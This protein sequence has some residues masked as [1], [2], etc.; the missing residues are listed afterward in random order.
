MPSPAAV[1]RPMTRRPRSKQSTTPWPRTKADMARRL[2]SA[3]R[4]AEIIRWVKCARKLRAGRRRFGKKKVVRKAGPK[5]IGC[6][7]KRSSGSAGVEAEREAKP[8]ETKTNP[9][10]RRRFGATIRRS[11]DRAQ[12]PGAT[13]RERQ[14]PARPSGERERSQ[15][16]HREQKAERS[17]QPDSLGW[18]KPEPKQRRAPLHRCRS[19][20]P[21]CSMEKP[22][23]RRSRAA[24]R[25][26]VQM[27]RPPVIFPD[28][29]H[30]AADHPITKHA[31]ATIIERVPFAESVAFL[32]DSQLFVKPDVPVPHSFTR[33]ISREARN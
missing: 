33:A 19:R 15:S 25:G 23:A 16:I 7:P 9:R 31:D 18:R 20:R 2:G 28:I 1:I 13:S 24:R 8:D 26:A 11:D 29:D 32:Q 6:A 12:T 22:V 10:E 21:G 30:P 4:G 14:C 3:C 27:K 17:S 5:S